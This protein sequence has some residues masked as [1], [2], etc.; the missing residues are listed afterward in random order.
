MVSVVAKIGGLVALLSLPLVLGAFETVLVTEILI[1]GLFAMGFDLI[2]GY[3]GMLS[4]GQSVFFGAGAYAVPWALLVGG[5]N[6]WVALGLAIVVGSVLS[7][8]VGSLAVKTTDHYF[9]ILTIIFSLV[10]SLVLQSG[11][12][13]WLTGGFGGRPFTIPTLP[14]G[15][16]ELNLVE[17]RTNFYFV[18][19]VVGAA[20]M[21]CRRLV[22]SP[23]GKVFVGI[24]ENE[25]RARLVGYRIE[26]YKL[27][28]FVVAGAVS[29]L[30]G[31]LYAVTFRYTNLIFFHWTTSSE[32]IVS[33]IVGGAGTLVGPY[34][35][36]GFLILFKDYVSSAVAYAGIVVGLVVIGVVRVAP[37]GVVGVMRALAERHAR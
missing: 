14:L 5:S 3:L 37:G 16:W 26:R 32:V 36:T 12:W 2:Y 20:F 29:G 21:A 10:I 35:G 25:D 17:P 18:I 13:R 7:A 6:L 1:W 19:A 33:T 11:H 34:L 30:A 24:R 4:F 23:L 28:A 15:P 9:L 27:V 22:T 8:A 31:G